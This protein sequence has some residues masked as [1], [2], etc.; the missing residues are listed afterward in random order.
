[1]CCPQWSIAAF[2]AASILFSRIEAL[3]AQAPS[4]IAPD[5]VCAKVDD[6]VIRYS[7]IERE[8][9]RLTNLKSIG[10][11]ERSI[12]E[13]RIREQ[14]IDRALALAAL[15]KMGK[16]ASRDDV[17]FELARLKEEL[18]TQGIPLQAHLAS[19]KITEAEFRREILWRLSWAKYLAEYLSEA[20][21]EKYFRE[22]RADYDGRKIRVAQILLK[23]TNSAPLAEQN[24][25]LAKAES[26][27]E[28]IV[29]GKT[30]FSDAAKLHSEA[31][32]APEG[33]DQGWIERREPM[34]EVFSKAAFALKVSETSAPVRSS[35]GV[36]LIHCL[37]IQEGKKTWRDV[38]RELERDATAY[39]GRWLADSQ[40]EKSQIERT[41]AL[42]PTQEK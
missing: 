14:L 7:D 8:R 22:H 39:L 40:R 29:S 35:F 34:G 36:H 24:A 13:A 31:P 1:M 16:S 30:S 20:N 41:S 33:G 23:Q 9:K 28:A 26:I 21:L 5:L 19:E 25:V 18:K 3:G 6:Q 4:E 37:E 2:F 32:S 42:P 17:D 38:R 15:Q 27:R 10:D 12:L 11:A